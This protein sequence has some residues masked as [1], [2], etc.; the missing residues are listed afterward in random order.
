MLAHERTWERADVVLDGLG[1]AD[2]AAARVLAAAGAAHHDH[3]GL[4]S[5][6]PS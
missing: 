2:S 5:A 6:N 1:P 3:E 4:R